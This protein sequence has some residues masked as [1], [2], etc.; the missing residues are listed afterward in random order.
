MSWKQLGSP[1]HEALRDILIERRQ[2]AKLTQTELAERLGRNQRYVSRIE[3]GEHRVTVV[4][5][6]ELA[7]ALGFDAMAVVRRIVNLRV[8]KS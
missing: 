1:R 2:R 8:G 3:T 4:D 7:E 6:V 5:L